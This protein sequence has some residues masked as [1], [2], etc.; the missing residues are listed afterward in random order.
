M[1]NQNLPSSWEEEHHTPH[2]K[3]YQEV[4][5]ASLAPILRLQRT[6]VLVASDR[7]GLDGFPVLLALREC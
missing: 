7:V 2:H 3:S 6:E 1:R 4:F 5:L